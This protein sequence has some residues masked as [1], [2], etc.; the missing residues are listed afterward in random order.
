MDDSAI[1]VLRET[2]RSANSYAEWATLAVVVGLIIEFGVLLIFAKEISRTE[3]WLLIFANILVAG[4]VG[5]EYVFGGRASTAAIQ[6]QQASDEKIAAFSNDAAEAKR[7]AANAIE[8]A[9]TLEK[10]A[11]IARASVADATARAA[12]ASRKAAEAELA[13]QKI[14]SPRMLTPA[15]Q[16]QISEIAKQFPKTPF[17]LTIFD[18]PEAVTFMGQIEDSLTAGGWL[19]KQWNAGASIV[20]LRDGKTTL[21]LNSMEGLY[22]QADVSRSIDF[23]PA[24]IAVANQLKAAGIAALSQIGPMPSNMDK[25][26]VFIQVGK[27]PL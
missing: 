4:G 13:L 8:R 10:D 12:E 2:F 6:L 24:V 3:K 14:K 11:A 9:A 15:Q 18:D 20:F 1:V 26:A 21:N 17:I 19:E 27:K 16:D 22:V 23:G 5:G 7:D 25:N